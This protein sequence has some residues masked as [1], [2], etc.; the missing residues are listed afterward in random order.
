MN[1]KM[2]KGEKEFLEKLKELNERAK[3][4][5]SKHFDSL[6]VEHS[7]EYH[8]KLESLITTISTNFINLPLDEIEDG[9]DKALGTLGKFFQVDRSYIFLYSENQTLMSNTY[10]WCAK[11]IESQK[12]H[13]Q[14]APCEMFP[15]FTEQMKRLETVY[16]RKMSDVP[17]EA[18]S[19]L[20]EWQRQDIKSII[21]VPMVCRKG[22]VGFVG[23]DSVRIE[24]PFADDTRILLRSIGELF[25]NTLARRDSEHALM[26]RT[27][28]LRVLIE[29]AERL[30][31]I[32]EVKVVMRELVAS[33]M[34][35]M[36]ATSGTAGTFK[37]GKMVFNEYNNG[38]KLLDIHFE[39]E[40]GYGVPGWIVK[41][42]AP[43]LSND[44]EHDEHVVPAIQKQLNFYNL[45][46]VPILSSTGALLG[47]FEIHNTEGRRDFN[48]QD[49]EMLQGLASL[50][51]VAIENAI[52]VEDRHKNAMALE[53]S[54][55]RFRDFF[56]KA[57]IG[58]HIFGP[59]RTIL[60]INQAE[61]DMIGY[62]RDEIVGKK[63]WSDLIRPK[64][65]KQ[66]EIHWKDI[67]SKGE[68][69]DLKYTLVH[70]NGNFVDVLLNASAR[71][72][73]DG[74]LVNTRGSVIDI[75]QTKKKDLALSLSEQ[76]FRAIADYTYDWENWVSPK[77]TLLWVN[78]GVE[79]ITG[80]TPAE[81][82]AMKDF[83]LPLIYEED[84]EN[85]K[86]SFRGAFEG[87]SANDLELRIQ[88][89]DD[90]V[91]WVSLSYQPIYD[92]KGV[93]QGH[94]SSLRD[95]TEKKQVQEAMRLIV[96][97]TAQSTGEDY[98]R[99]L[100]QHLAK[101][102]GCR[103]VL[104][105]ELSET[106]TSKIQTH[107][108]WADGKFAENFEYEL[109]GTPCENVVGNKMCVYP[110]SV[111]EQ[112]PE[113]HLLANMSVESYVGT[114]LFDSSG[115]ALGLL[116]VM[117]IEPM[118]TVVLVESALFI[119]ALRAATEIERTRIEKEREELLKT[120]S[121]KNKELESIVYV[122]SH[123]LRSPL[124]NIQG[125]CSE[126]GNSCSSLAKL[127]DDEK[128]E[129]KQLKKIGK[130]IS[131]EIPESLKYIKGGT[132]K[133]DMLLNGLLRMSRLGG[134]SLRVKKINMNK[135]IASILSN[136]NHRIE[137]V[138]ADV[139]VEPLDVCTG[140]VSQI[141]QV[142][143]NLLENALKFLDPKREGKIKISCETQNSGC[144][145][146]IEDNG[147]G[148][149]ESHI[150]K[151]FQIFQRLNPTKDVPG[152]GLGLTIVR[153]IL[154]RNDG[155]IW[156]ESESGVGSKFYVLL[157][158]KHLSGH[159]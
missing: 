89:K 105:G 81:C 145:Y 114:P 46:D 47:C 92:M 85:V 135:M 19:V 76:R 116:S 112:F 131:D 64:Q 71:F 48:D 119:F 143:T 124:L 58:F 2:N 32:L 52:L 54:E 37:N 130:L 149:E 156:V 24:R 110:K 79:R 45:V 20:A 62:N 56:Q 41:T 9:I 129:G 140:D 27:E 4:Y 74:N 138:G 12:D 144:V 133:I 10:E 155:K 17:A 118:R 22:L 57:P 49:V 111:Q 127:F 21:C 99:G 157:P 55:D 107:L 68:A 93:S 125:Y 142:F 117:D 158:V 73:Q 154:D 31:A 115:K 137:K 60:D 43:Y 63:S 82:M 95:I 120:L 151:A 132:T 70:K 128:I 33:A 97:G 5:E 38:G 78:P 23:F 50:A 67:V 51:S 18:K 102:T 44:T 153:R 150:E 100:V 35:L 69:K 104:L 42:R 8:L 146:C 86:E 7:R 6:E 134:A 66:F 75:T 15:W 123:D 121:A 109:K 14:D 77:G 94:R 30:N 40:E 59:D 39:F 90:K 101:A 96:E 103:Y 87:Q 25:A 91:I 106:D 148:M 80:Y 65:I 88:R 1:D 152:E 139:K 36:K 126:L 16:F 26:Q 84:R 136:M 29:A 141:N 83:P 113:D 147:I 3:Y 98:L 61:L 34:E 28:Q 122:S 53:N 13:L 11:G 108:V 159:V 72:D